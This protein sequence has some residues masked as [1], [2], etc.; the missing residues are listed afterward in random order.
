MQ[1]DSLPW[2]MYDSMGFGG[3]GGVGA[4]GGTGVPVADRQMPQ[5][6]S[7]TSVVDETAEAYIQATRGPRGPRGEEPEAEP[8]KKAYT[9]AKTPDISD[10]SEVSDFVYIVIA[11][12]FIDVVVLFLTRYFP[13]LMGRN[14][15]RWY[16]LFGLNA[17]IA[18]VLIIV[19]G[20]IIARY[21]Y[22]KFV[23]P[24]FLNGAWS[25]MAFT[26]TL[27]GVQAIHDLLFYFGVIL[28]IPR[29]HNTM[30]DVFK[31]YAAS[32]GAKILGGDALMMIGSTAVATILKGT[33]APIVAAF[34]F[35]TLYAVPYILYTRN[36]FTILR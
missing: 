4:G 13:D 14:L 36:Q 5:V 35:L 16:D 29:G 19:I 22:T 34:G 18:D 6:S 8:K 17:V 10:P 27:V 7:R 15:N 3:G 26:G 1:S 11:V 12:L 9:T 25:P 24:K 33:T 28:Q 30:I 32:G 2:T 31:D 23:A 20:F 21:V